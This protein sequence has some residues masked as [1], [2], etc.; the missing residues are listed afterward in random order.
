[1]N[2]HYLKVLEYFLE[3]GEKKGIKKESLLHDFSVGLKDYVLKFQYDS[4]ENKEKYLRTTLTYIIDFEQ[5]ENLHQGIFHDPKEVIKIISSSINFIHFDIK[6]F[7]ADTMHRNLATLDFNEKGKMGISG[8][9]VYGGGYG[10][11][12]Q[13]M[14]YSHIERW[15][16]RVKQNV[17][18]YKINIDK[19]LDLYIYGTPYY[20]CAHKREEYALMFPEDK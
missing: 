16:E 17:N 10:T 18:D 8:I 13:R 11:D 1:M 12:E 5:K 14:L 9:T 15:K 6:D 2:N 3:S 20:T 4:E 19:I 7:S